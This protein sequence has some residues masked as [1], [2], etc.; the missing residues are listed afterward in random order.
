MYTFEDYLVVA[1]INEKL[2]IIKKK[3]KTNFPG[4]TVEY[5]DVQAHNL[6]P[7]IQDRSDISL[8]DIGKKFEKA[9][10][11]MIKKNEKGFFKQKTMVEFTLTKSQFKVLIMINPDDSYIRFSTIL[12]MDMPSKNTIKWKLSEKIEI[13]I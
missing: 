12:S 5:H 4:Y 3:W 9:I 13:E 10:N 2:T 7:R 8:A 11:Y 1:Y 6:I